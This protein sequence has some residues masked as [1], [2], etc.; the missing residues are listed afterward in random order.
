[1]MAMNAWEMHTLLSTCYSWVQKSI[2]ERTTIQN[3]LFQMQDHHAPSQH[4]IKLGSIT[5]LMMMHLKN[6]LICNFM[7]FKNIFLGA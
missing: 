6:Q 2:Q 5:Q 1:M 4:T 3:T 7:V